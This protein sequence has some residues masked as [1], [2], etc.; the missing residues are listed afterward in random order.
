MRRVRRIMVA[1]G[2]VTAIAIAGAVP[3]GADHAQRADLPIKAV[4]AILNGDNEVPGPGDDDGFGAAGLLINTRTGRV[5]F[6][7]FVRHIAA[8]TAA[9]IHVGGPTVAG[10]VVVP[11]EPPPTSGFSVGCAMASPTLAADIANNPGNYYVN[12]HNA[13]FPAG[14]IRGQLH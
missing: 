7:L 9:H 14:A 3:A 11:L 5:C 2:L 8:A 10:P 13:E 6:A 4:G 12:V 1:A